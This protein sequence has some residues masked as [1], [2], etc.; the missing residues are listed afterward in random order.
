MGCLV[1]TTVVCGYGS[2]ALLYNLESKLD[3]SQ[4]DS[5][6][7]Q[8]SD[9]AVESL[10][11][12]VLSLKSVSSTIG[13][14]CP[15]AEQW[16]NCSINMNSFLD[17]ADPIIE[18]AK[19][20]AIAFTPIIS[21]SQLPEFEAYA[22]EFLKEDGY[23]YLGVF[24]FGKGVYS[25]NSTINVT[26]G[27]PVGR[28]H[29]V[30]GNGGGRHDILTPVIQIGNLEENTAAVMFNLY[31]QE[32]RINAIDFMI[33]CFN[34][35]KSLTSCTSITDIIHL[36]QDPEF[37]PAVLIIHPLVPKY[38]QTELKGLTYTVH[39]WDTILSRSLPDYVFG[40]V[41][42]LHA[43]NT[44]YS[45][46]ITDGQA[47]FIGDGDLHDE[48][49]S[50]RAKH[51]KFDN[52]EGSVLYSVSVYPTDQYVA[53]F[54][55]LGPVYA[56]VM[57]V[58]IIIFTSI[59]FLLYDHFMNRNAIEKELVIN[60]KRLFVR[61]ISHEIRTPLNT[62]H[63]GL[64][65]LIDEMSNFLVAMMELKDDR[66]NERL[67]DW[68]SLITDIE[69]SSDTAIVVLNDL[70]NY[71]KIV[72]GSLNIEI[73]E[74][75]LWEV[76]SSNVKPF[77]VQARQANVSLVLKMVPFTSDA[78]ATEARHLFALGDSVKL[79]QVVRNLVSNAVKFTPSGGSVIVTAS[80]NPDGL[81]DVQ[82]EES[83]N[84]RA[85]S[86]IVE[87]V[88]TGAGLSKDNQTKLFMEGMQFNANSLQ[89]GGGSGLGL[90][91]AKGVV[92]LHQGELRASSAGEGRG[93]T[94][95]LEIPLLRSEK[96]LG[97]DEEQ[98]V[99]RMEEPEVCVALP[100]GQVEKDST[101]RTVLVVDDSGPSRKVV[102]R[103]LR[104]AGY[105]CHQANDG[106]HCLEYF[107]QITAAGVI[108]DL[109][110]MDFEMPRLDGPSATKHLRGEGCKI[111]II[112]VTG[113]VLPADRD[114][115]LNHGANLVLHKPLRIA[116]LEQAVSDLN[117][118]PK[119]TVSIHNG[120][121]SKV[122]P[123]VEDEPNGGIME[124]EL[125]TPN[126]SSVHSYNSLSMDAGDSPGVI[127]R[128]S[129]V[130]TKSI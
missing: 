127:V 56:S 115:F 59:I 4:Y 109:I 71:D 13:L 32:K 46:R 6:A 43:G 25:V 111:P 21:P 103:L 129:P 112:G 64:K 37:R 77:F 14:Y 101:V 102:C 104:N 11:A 45:F 47:N 119:L 106:Q 123:F 27:E 88:D 22:Y 105:V 50:S 76:I 116:E 15:Y 78:T 124:L 17:V 5:L 52:F 51:F 99:G 74:V 58:T 57:A 114:H 26:T 83:E 122:S 54:H 79:G 55:T 38:N 94:F 125:T 85:G 84:P 121:N 61:F 33:D 7:Q 12:K 23:D 87:V 2:Y 97:Q 66:I 31:S 89:A 49:Y 108:I 120:H 34:E 70:I 92:N 42:V 65:L 20:R 69:D 1:A 126:K 35:T 48:K 8:L 18:L 53:Q 107:K 39:N 130:T 62:V 80:W 96:P 28:Y 36:V 3:R 9:S 81:P 19:M 128:K 75:Y 16:P 98:E 93:T 117:N 10:T 40:I 82:F 30:N 100:L 73:D 118:K 68:I 90:Y 60:T 44:D 91:I 110:L 67:N 63:L 29:D 41:A 113:N 24:E 72:M 95:H 86:L